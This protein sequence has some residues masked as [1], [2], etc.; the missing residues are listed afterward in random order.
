MP[1]PKSVREAAER[2]VEE[3]F[4]EDG[5]LGA[6]KTA[7]DDLA[8]ALSAPIAG[9]G[10]TDSGLSVGQKPS[11]SVTDDVENSGSS[12]AAAFPLYT[13]TVKSDGPTTVYVVEGGDGFSVD[14]TEAEG[15]AREVLDELHHAWDN[16]YV[17]RIIDEPSVDWAEGYKDKAIAAIMDES[18]VFAGAYAN[19][20]HRPELD[21][22]SRRLQA[23][24]QILTA[25]RANHA[26]AIDNDAGVTEGAP[27]NPES[28]TPN[29]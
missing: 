17:Y 1:T 20:P 27:S 16:G 18:A 26:Q 14:F 10:E 2:A 6:E 13:L 22:A 9:G 8:T 11:P 19:A 3:Y 28:E 12:V 29:A 25:T 23:L 7:M 21:R 4:H 5:T 24:A 15:K